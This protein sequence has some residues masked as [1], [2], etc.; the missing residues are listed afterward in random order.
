MYGRLYH[1]AGNNPVRYIDP[2]GRASII[3][4]VINDS[5]TNKNYHWAHI[6]GGLMQIPCTL[7]KERYRKEHPKSWG[8]GV[9]F[10][11]ESHM[12]EISSRAGEIYVEK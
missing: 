4:R 3:L 7:R 10:A 6:I 12:S 11:W 2:D 8:I 9:F 1:Y 5:S